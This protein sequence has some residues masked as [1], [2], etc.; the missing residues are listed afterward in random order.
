M[1][2]KDLKTLKEFF[3][4][5]N[6]PIFGAGV[7]AFNRLGLEDILPDYKIF[8]LR[9]SLDTKLIEKDIEILSL[10]K[11]MG[12]NHIKEPRNSTTVIKHP[13][14]K[15]YIQGLNLNNKKP[16][17][18]VYKPSKKMEHACKENNWRLIANPSEFGKDLF[19]DKIKFRRILQEIGISIPPGK[20]SSLEKLHYGHLMNKYNLPFVIQ[21]PLRGGGKGT[22]FINSLDDFNN[23][24]KK[25]GATYDEENNKEIIPP[26]QVIINKF[27][28]GPSPSIT[29]CVTKDGI[30]S[31]NLQ[32][33]VLDIPQ[34]Y[35]PEKGSGLFCGHDWTSSEFNEEI[36][37][38]ARN[39]AEKIGN[40]F[41]KLGYRGIFGL[42]FILDEK[43]KKLYTIECNPRLLGSYPTINMAQ[44]LNN[45]PPILA[46]HVLSFL[47][48]I[49]YEIDIETINKLMR[50]KKKGA[51]ML[52][53]N[54]SGRWAKNK[55]EL[56][57]GIYKLENGKL[58]YLRKGY[59]LK[60]LKEKEEFLLADGVPFKKSHFSPNRRLCRILTLNK[61]L[62]NSNYKE[63]NPWAKQVAETVY[64]G[65]KIR[66]IRFIKIKK[67]IFPNFLAKG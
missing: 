11:K 22:F 48:N 36:S 47:E 51:Q 41:K 66:P 17:F 30:I 4:K 15:K 27:I 59:D 20:I 63:L 1:I 50:Q 40:Y 23:A 54:L 10:E 14:I 31:T 8:A 60:H 2:I 49:D 64:N 21:H 44:M 24:L 67:F 53:H 65:F 7:Y 5:I 42:D 58:K 62:D 9:Y 57:A 43:T 29:A 6:A 35:S 32:H 18:L 13:K 38:Q 12:T 34:L 61:V 19:E 16:S 3:Q 37:E 28:Q 52:L 55:N 39:N 56:K 25:L 26:T 33:Q 46:F 45:E